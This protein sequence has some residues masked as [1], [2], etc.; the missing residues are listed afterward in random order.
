MHLLMK[1]MND[2][3]RCQ[4][5]SR[6]ACMAPY[7]LKAC[8]ALY[9]MELAETPGISQE[10]LAARIFADKSNVARQLAFLE[11]NGYVT[12]HASEK[13]KRAVCVYLTEKAEALLPV[14]RQNAEEWEMCVMEV[15]TRE[16]KEQLAA[17]LG[18]LRKR[19]ESQ[20][21]G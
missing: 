4:R 18:K 1:D 20:V 21:D 16:E 19:L 13:D 5:Q 7:G 15:M 11:E 14:I 8:H 6:S 17:L 10:R 2:I 9:L 12:R 3:V